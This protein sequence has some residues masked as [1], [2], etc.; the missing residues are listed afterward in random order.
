MI[1]KGQSPKGHDGVVEERS[2][3]GVQAAIENDFG[4]VPAR[5]GPKLAQ[6]STAT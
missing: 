4:G 6:R 3:P 5:R 2:W 1:N